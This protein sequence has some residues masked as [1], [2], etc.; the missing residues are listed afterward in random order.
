MGQPLNFALK[1]RIAA[2]QLLNVETLSDFTDMLLSILAFVR[3]I[4]FRL[5]LP[6]GQVLTTHL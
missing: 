3:K 5:S 6:A 4:T 1:L 2:P